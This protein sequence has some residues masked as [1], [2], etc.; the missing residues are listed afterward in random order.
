ML[1]S[2][3]YA[4]ASS[5]IADDLGAPDGCYFVG[6]HENVETPTREPRGPFATIAD[7]EAWAAIMDGEFGPYSMRA[8]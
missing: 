4:Y 1:K 2:I 7:A 6:I 5:K 8:A 3:G